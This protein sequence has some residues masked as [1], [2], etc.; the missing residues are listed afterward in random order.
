MNETLVVF[1]SREEFNV[2]F[3]NISAVVASS[4]PIPVG[5]KYDL[6]VCGVGMLEFSVN[7]S[8]ILSRV[9]Y[10]RVFLLGAC[11]AYYG[12]DL[13][14]CDIV[15]VDSDIVGDMGVQTAEGHFVPWK[16]YSGS[17][18]VYMG[19]SPRT[20]P[21]SLASVPSVAGVSVNCSSGT[22]Y[23]SLRRSGMYSADVE[24]MEGAALFAVCQKFGVAGYQFRAVCCVVGS[25][26]GEGKF[27]EALEL[28]KSRVLDF[29]S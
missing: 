28:L 5:A 15:R 25:N 18:C 16:D 17:E 3:P 4:T 22:R 9:C 2:F 12:H 20:L 13:N 21:L 24:T 26:P 8:K 1:A 29:I 23:F 7:L 10:K 11:G 6:A 27:V 19:E 14:V